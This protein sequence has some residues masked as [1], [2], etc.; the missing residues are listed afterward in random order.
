MEEAGFEDVQ[1][2]IYK[3]WHHALET[4]TAMVESLI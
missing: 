4:A 2:K 3:V 1:Q